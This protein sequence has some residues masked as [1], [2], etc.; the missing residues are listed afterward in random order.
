MK[1][2]DMSNDKTKQSNI[3]LRHMFQTDDS[4]KV[5]VTIPD[6][7]DDEH[8]NKIVVK[9]EN[10]QGKDL[11]LVD[12]VKQLIEISNHQPTESLLKYIKEL[13]S[14]YQ[15]ESTSSDSLDIMEEINFD[16]II[17][18]SEEELRQKDQRAILYELIEDINRSSPNKASYKEEEFETNFHQILKEEEEF[19]EI[20][21][22]ESISIPEVES[23][24]SETIQDLIDDDVI[25]EKG[26]GKKGRNIAFFSFVIIGLIV[27][28]YLYQTE[29]FEFFSN[30]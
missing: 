28:F 12:S 11:T 30:F 6:T 24:H 4:G 23:V 15:S 16:E 21:E 5:T 8:L 1:S 27:I 17:L 7:L 22:D 18:K 10:K 3:R 2:N 25:Q 14:R 13:K 9:F 19:D 26:K 29:I 20:E